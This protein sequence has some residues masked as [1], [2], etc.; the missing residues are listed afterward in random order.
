MKFLEENFILLREWKS[1][2][3][4]N[5]LGRRYLSEW[6]DGRDLREGRQ[7]EGQAEVWFLSSVLF[8]K[9]R[10]EIAEQVR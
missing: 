4:R 3:C 9:A 10:E 7:T 8:E 1:S 5:S 2:F 6:G